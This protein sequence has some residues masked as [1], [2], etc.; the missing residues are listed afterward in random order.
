MV[1]PLPLSDRYRSIVFFLIF[2]HFESRC[3]MSY[4]NCS[5]KKGVHCEIRF[6]PLRPED[7]LPLISSI[8][9]EPQYSLKFLLLKIYTE[10]HHV[11][12]PRI[13]EDPRLIF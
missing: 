11:K 4:T 3:L 8:S 9:T 6:Y 12:N 5:H 2:E 10:N 7:I 13:E 1:V